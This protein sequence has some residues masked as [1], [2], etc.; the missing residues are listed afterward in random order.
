MS[1]IFRN[2]DL[3]V[4]SDIEQYKK[5]QSIFETFDIK[6]TYGV[7]PQGKNFY[8][9]PFNLPV[10]VV[11]ESLG[12]E[13]IFSNQAVDEFIKQCLANGHHIALHG[14]L[15]TVIIH[16]SFDEQYQFIKQGKE[17]LENQYQT[18]IKYFIAPFNCFNDQTIRAC[19]L[20]NLDLLAGN[21]NQ[22]EWLVRDNK[23]FT[24]DNFCW[25]HAR[26]FFEGSLTPDKLYNFLCNHLQNNQHKS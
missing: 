6:E 13:F 16:Y 1:I 21:Q 18:E 22:L 8:I 26:R 9:N 3:A 5:I 2:D 24:G 15:H 7:V 12:T 23:P 20:L 4:D 19:R 14:W 25:Y 17:L 11:E 10:R